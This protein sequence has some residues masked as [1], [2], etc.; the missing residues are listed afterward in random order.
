MH[1]Q[2]QRTKNGTDALL[3][4]GPLGLS[5]LGNID[6]LRAVILPL[7][8]HIIR[9]PSPLSPVTFSGEDEHWL[10]VPIKIEKRIKIF[11]HNLPSF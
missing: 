5:P 2:E 3:A 4:K 1:D 10:L 11:T 7:P 9:Y 8:S 6:T